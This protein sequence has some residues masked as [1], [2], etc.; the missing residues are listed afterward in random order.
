MIS[1][2]RYGSSIL[3]FIISILSL[4]TDWYG[5]LITAIVVVV[6]LSMIHKLGKGILLKESIAF[7]YILTCLVMPMVGYRYYSYGNTL[8]KIWVGYMR[9]PQEVYFDYTLPAVSLFSFAIMLPLAGGAD[10]SNRLQQSVQHIKAVMSKD[11]RYGIIMLCTGFVFS[12]TSPYLPAGLQF[13]SALF[14]FSSFAG[15]LYIYFSPDFKYKKIL[16]WLFS[17]SIFANSLSIG[18]FTI[19]VYMGITVFSYFYLGSK[20]SFF[21]KLAIFIA[22]VAFLILLQNVK[23]GYRKYIWQSGYGGNKALLFANIM[24]DNIQKGD[25]LIE[26]NAFFPLYVRANQGYNVSLVMKRI[27]AIKPFDG[28]DRLATVFASAFVPRF[29]WPDKPEAGGKFNMA[30]YAGRVIQGWSTNVGPLGEAYG[31]FGVSGGIIY[32]FFLGL[33]IRWI[34]ARIFKVA[35][36]IPLLICWL[37]VFFFQIISSAETDSLQIF[38]SLIKAAFFVW[39]LYK[40]IPQWFGSATKTYRKATPNRMAGEAS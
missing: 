13:F 31:S 22:G 40:V 28:G 17:I 27:P 8:S 35:R 37:P 12:L 23:G 15:L 21:K 26:K 14:Y 6:I 5:V 1:L 7:I 16:L 4:T 25:A 3:L 33:F 19:V 36:N 24:A 38:N 32:M 39:L 29:L 9:V 18:M 20:T 11:Y 30:Y 34:Y 10:T 2:K